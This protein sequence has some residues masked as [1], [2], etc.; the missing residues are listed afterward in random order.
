M[1]LA[2]PG[3]VTNIDHGTVPLMGTVDFGGVAKRVCLDW[4]PGVC[5]G[6]YV[7]VH[8][9]FAIA[10]VD[11]EEARKTIALARAMTEAS[12]GEDPAR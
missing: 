12:L 2:I 1:C 9:G 11:E 7:I 5:A 3:S 10:V 4:V 6:Q 8:V